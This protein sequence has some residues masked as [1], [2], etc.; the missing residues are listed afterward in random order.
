MPQGSPAVQCSLAMLLH[1]LLVSLLTLQSCEVAPAQL[2]G[3]WTSRPACA[4]TVLLS[5]SQDIEQLC[6]AS[7]SD[8]CRHPGTSWCAFSIAVE[9]SPTYSRLPAS[10]DQALEVGAAA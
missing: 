9:W 7:S 1:T 4:P 5:L 8:L 10:G 6:D 2:T 3:T